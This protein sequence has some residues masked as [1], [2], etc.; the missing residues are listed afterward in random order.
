LAFARFTTAT[1]VPGNPL[2]FDN[3]SS[4]VIPSPGTAI[5]SVFVTNVS[6]AV[7]NVTVSMFVEHD[8][9]YFLKLELI[10]PDG[11]TNV[12]SANNGLFGQN[13]GIACSPE[14]Q[15]TTFDDAASTAIAS[16]S[17]PFIGSF[18]P[19]QP[20]SVFNGR[21]GTNVNGIWQLR[22]IDQGQFDIG[23]IHCWSLF[24]TPTLSTDGGG[25]CPG[26]DLALGMTAL[27]DPVIIGNNMTY[28]I[29]VTNNGPS[30][31]TNVI[32]TLVL[33]DSVN[34]AAA[35]TSQGAFSQQGNVVTFTLGLM[36]I[37]AK[38]TMSVVGIPTVPG[39]VS[40]TATASSEQPD[41]V[42]ANSSVSVSSHIRPLTADLA[43][44]IAAV[45]NPVLIGGALTYTISLANNGPS[46]IAPSDTNPIM[47]T[48][49]LPSSVQIQSTMVSTGT[50]TPIGSAILWK[51]PA[52]LDMGASASATITVIPT[53]EGLIRATA[54]TGDP[55][56][57]FDP[58][59]A[60]NTAAITI[61]V[62]PASDLALGLNGP[63]TVVTTSNVTYTIAV[64][65]LGP[66]DATGVTVNQSFS[67]AVTNF[68]WNV[69]PLASGAWASRTNVVATRN[70]GTLSTTATV[71]GT[72]TDPDPTN[73]TAGLT[74]IV[75]A[76]FVSIVGAGATLTYESGPTNGAID[77]GETVTLSLRL[78][79]DGNTNTVNL[80]ATLLATDGVAPI[81]GPDP[82]SPSNSQPYDLP[83]GATLGHSFSFTASGTNGQTIHPTL[84][85]QDGIK[86]YDPVS[87]AF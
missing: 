43:L 47:V 52:G 29:S 49:L 40:A 21:S 6:Y 83:S 68:T 19:D 44:A 14:S 27:P 23:S 20:L 4:V 81:T 33:P 3:F 82:L 30:A 26:T 78:R 69:G 58:N 77:I 45:P 67:P 5:S 59:T 65:N 28:D 66:S 8:F 55:G 50:V 46:A 32:V 42:P 7:N 85:L 25:E 18:K 80:V 73:N 54:T 34:L 10:A 48:N 53:V 56:D 9:D 13:Y 1:G 57:E 51:L 63:G 71:F 37:R 16:G 24:L 62:G 2:Q 61:T 41:F 64:T 36:G 38:A 12:L 39:V 84:Q 17:A 60:N 22:A 86:T 31:A 74:T 11:T 72:Q 79:N 76:P 87:F 35:Y 75:A 70:N 15:R